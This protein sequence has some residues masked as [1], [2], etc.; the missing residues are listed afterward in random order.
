[1]RCGA[2][3]PE[4]GRPEGGEPRGAR[5]RGLA[6][7]GRLLP[8]RRRL[9]ASDR[10]SRDRRRWSSSSPTRRC[11]EQRRLSVEIRLKLYEE[12]IAPEILE[13]L[14]AAWRAQRA[15]E[16]PAGRGPLL[17]ADRGSR[18]TPTSPASSKASSAS[19]DEAEFL[20]AV[21][22]CWA[23]LWTSQCAPLHGQP[24]P[25]PGRHRDGG[26]DPADRRRARLGR[27][28]E[29]DRRRPDADQRDL[30]PRLRDRAGRGGAR[31]HRAR[32]ARASC[33][34]SRPAARIIARPAAT[35]APRRRR[36]R[37]SSCASRASTPGRR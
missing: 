8:D 14:L 10:A 31:P 16:R 28:P 11:D 36:C 9:S 12:P 13:P 3:D 15:D 1:M 18:R 30:G 34:R 22:A 32:R 23:A 19:T 33:A 7:A 2:T 6:D 21:R 37:R 35:A 17:G 27:R 29:R 4:R 20:T 24:R 25:Q 5:A 26:A